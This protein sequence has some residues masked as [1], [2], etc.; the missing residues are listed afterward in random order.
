MGNLFERGLD[1]NQRAQLGAHYTS[2]DDIRT[3][4]EPVLMAPLRREWSKIKAE[5]APAFTRGEGKSAE[6]AKLTAFHNKLASIT[7]LDPA[8]GSGNF[9]YV[10]LKLLL[11]LEKEVITFAT[12]NSASSWNRTSPFSN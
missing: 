7:V 11:D 5:L 12:P 10:S 2:E 6:R 4:V 1:P 8:C 9:L 3:L